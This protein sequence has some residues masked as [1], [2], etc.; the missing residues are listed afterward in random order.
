MNT[1][2]LSFISAGIILAAA[3]TVGYV[4]SKPAGLVSQREMPVFMGEEVIV[5]K[6]VKALKGERAL[7][8][9]KAVK[10]GKAVSIPATQPKAAAPLPIFPPRIS[11]RVL[12]QYPVSALEQGLEGTTILS[13][14]VGLTGGAEKV[15]VKSSSGAVELDKSAVKAVSQWRFDPASQGGAAIASWFELPVRFELENQGF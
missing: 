7:K 8:V 6:A 12:P 10:A 4:I 2:T 11:Y 9:E 14:Y 1:K 5:N 13:V 3:L 15:A